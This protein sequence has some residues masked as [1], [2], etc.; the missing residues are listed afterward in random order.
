MYSG[1]VPCFAIVV[2]LPDTVRCLTAAPKGEA[3]PRRRAQLA[4][5]FSTTGKGSMMGIFK[6]A[7][8]SSGLGYH[9]FSIGY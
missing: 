2:S 6:N 8:V 7:I 5:D 3:Q 9:D 4:R 1:R